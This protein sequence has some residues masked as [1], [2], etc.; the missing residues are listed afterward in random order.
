MKEHEAKLLVWQSELRKGSLYE[1]NKLPPDPPLNRLALG[2][3]VFPADK[4]M[5]SCII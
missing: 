1:P 4:G 5:A 3:R 2:F